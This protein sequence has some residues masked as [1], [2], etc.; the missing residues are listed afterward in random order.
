MSDEAIPSDIM[1]AARTANMTSR[2]MSTLEQQA[3]IIA[4]A[5]QAERE[6]CNK[7]WH[8]AMIDRDKVTTSPSSCGN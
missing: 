4:R 5:I 6:R 3:E 1:E 8:Q 2:L 7:R